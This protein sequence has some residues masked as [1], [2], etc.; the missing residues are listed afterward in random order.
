MFAP[1]TY[2]LKKTTKD[3]FYIFQEKKNFNDSNNHIFWLFSLYFLLKYV[4]I[5]KHNKHYDN[6]KNKYKVLKTDINNVD[7]FNK[8]YI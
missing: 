3:F 4:Y 2:F 7:I 5:I 8:L 1:K 6:D